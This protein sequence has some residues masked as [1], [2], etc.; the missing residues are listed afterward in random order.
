MN[1]RKKNGKFRK[2]Q[3]FLVQLNGQDVSF[4]V[5][6]ADIDNGVGQH[7]K[8]NEALRELLAN[9]EASRFGGVT[10]PKGYCTGIASTVNDYSIQ[11]GTI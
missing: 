7:T 11:M 6:K 8:F 4:R 9:M 1:K 2:S 5:S 10:F 3:M